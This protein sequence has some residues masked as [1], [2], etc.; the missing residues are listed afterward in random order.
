MA[1]SRRISHTPPTSTRLPTPVSSAC[2]HRACHHSFHARS[3]AGRR[4]P[5]ARLYSRGFRKATSRSLFSPEPLNT[6]LRAS[7]RPQMAMYYHSNFIADARYAFRRLARERSF[8]LAAIACLA[9]GIGANTAIFTVVNGVLLRQLPFA[10]PERVVHVWQ[11]WT[12]KAWHDEQISAPELRDYQMKARSV[13]AVAG[14]LTSGTSLADGDRVRRVQLALVTP[15]FFSVVGVPP[16][17]G[18]SFAAEE[19]TIPGAVFAVISASLWNATFARDPSVVGREVV[20]N[21]RKVT[22]LGI[23]PKDFSFPEGVDIWRPLVIGQQANDR[24][25]HFINVLARLRPGVS[26]AAASAEFNA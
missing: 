20:M 16:A 10:N 9:L 24:S 21:G 4:L 12:P 18:R 22:I 5:A 15:E 17:I 1:A 14:Y 26:V 23:M 3:T 8:T 25:Q 11:T 6:R 7:L 2:G 13:E 19:A